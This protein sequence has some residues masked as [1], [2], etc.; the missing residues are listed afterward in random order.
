M[1]A[2]YFTILY[3]FC[4]TSTW[5]CQGCTHVLHP[6]PPSHLPP[7]TIPLGHPSAPA[8]SILY[9]ASNLDCSIFQVKQLIL[10]TS[11]SV[12][13]AFWGV[14]LSVLTINSST[15]SIHTIFPN[16]LS[17]ASVIGYLSQAPITSIKHGWNLKEISPVWWPY[18][19]FYH[20]TTLSPI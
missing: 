17:W 11:S 8:A 12:L 14:D 7:P 3:W 6:E 16:E 18:L 2:N 9:P 1:K 5:I 13:S 15:S 10:I 4:H 20:H 19:N